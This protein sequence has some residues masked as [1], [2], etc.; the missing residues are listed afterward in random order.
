MRRY[1]KLFHPDGRAKVVHILSTASLCLICLTGR[2]PAPAAEPAVGDAATLPDTAGSAPSFTRE[3]LPNGLTIIVQANSSSDVVGMEIVSRVGTRQEEGSRAG[4][5]ALTVRVMEEGTRSWKGP[6]LRGW[7]EDRGSSIE[8]RVHPDYSE[9]GAAVVSSQWP[10]MARIFSSLVNEALLAPESISTMQAAMIN[11]ES[12]AAGNEEAAA[13]ADLRTLLSGGTAYGRSESGSAATLANLG[14]ADVTAFYRR[15]VN[16]SNLVVV[17]AGNVKAEDGARTLRTLFSP[18]QAETTVY[19]PLLPAAVVREPTSLVTA[20]SGDAAWI[21]VGYPTPGVLDKDYATATVLN[22]VIG[23]S[24]S[25]LLTSHF[26]DQAGVYESGSFLQPFAYQTHIAGYVRADPLQ[27]D[28]QAQKM[29]PLVD[30]FQKDI[31]A[32]FDGLQ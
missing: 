18:L 6:A 26:R 17:L 1:H 8:A 5:A 16:P 20:G 30:K 3:V 29:R 7:F 19:P 27:W 28:Q 14:P 15:L 32:I 24:N 21:M 22:A 13:Y 25:G 2:E 9:I 31:A 10:D 12:S 11:E 4:V 23:G